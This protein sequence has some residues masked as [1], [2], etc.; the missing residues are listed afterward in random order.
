LFALGVVF[1]IKFLKKTFISAIRKKTRPKSSHLKHFRADFACVIVPLIVFIAICSVY[2]TYYAFSRV[3]YSISAK[4]VIPLIIGVWTVFWGL[5]L[6][7]V[8]FSLRKQSIMPS[9]T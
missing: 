2:A 9:I 6:L 3:F 8:Y 5:V 7:K 4:E 1:T